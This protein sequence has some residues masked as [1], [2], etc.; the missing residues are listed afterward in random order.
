MGDYLMLHLKKDALK[1]T[2]TI[3]S[4]STVEEG[5]LLGGLGEEEEPKE[6]PLEENASEEAATVIRPLATGSTYI[7]SWKQLLSIQLR[8]HLRSMVNGKKPQRTTPNNFLG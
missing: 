6:E 8:L 1:I 3:T 5:G 4:T 7:W 2:Q